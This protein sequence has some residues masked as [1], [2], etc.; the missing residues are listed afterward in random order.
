MPA[1]RRWSRTTWPAWR[2]LTAPLSFTVRPSGMLVADSLADTS[3]RTATRA[4]VAWVPLT[5]MVA[6]CLTW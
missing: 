2:G 5:V 6:R 3:G 4:R 1:L